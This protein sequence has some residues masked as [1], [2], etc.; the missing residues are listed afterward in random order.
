MK[1]DA[2]TSLTQ[3][4]FPVM[5]SVKIDGFRCWLDSEPLTTRLVRFR[6]QAF[7]SQ[8]GKVGK[9]LHNRNVSLDGEVVVG[10]R[11][12][13]HVLGRT[14]SGVTSTDG[15]P[16]W[17]FWVF[18]C[19]EDDDFSV[20]YKTRWLRAKEIVEEIDDPRVR[21]VK[22][23]VIHNLRDLEA[24][25]DEALELGFEGVMGRSLDGMYKQG[26][27][28]IRQG[29]LWKWKPF[30]E[31][32]GMITDYYEQEKNN[33]EAKREAT[34]KLKRSSAKSG[35]EPKGVLGGVVV[36][37]IKTGVTGIRVGGGFTDAERKALWEVR[38][39][40]RGKVIT[41]SK[42]LVGEKDKPRSPQFVK[43]RH[44]WDFTPEY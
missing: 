23:R 15:K 42:Q 10:S 32:E 40:L 14:S 4:R 8:L 39:Q 27:S 38:D 16:D 35:K 18:D 37:D 20:P 22:Q 44:S 26:R 28:T 31:A 1:G 30:I 21:I 33:N 12:K 29:D 25:I 13:G 3:V 34:G 36:T 43:F 7:H 17:R 19:I 41:Y 5:V 9:R 24:F 11:R 2:L 6:N